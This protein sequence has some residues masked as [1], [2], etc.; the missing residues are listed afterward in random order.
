MG[1]FME[2]LS[3]PLMKD[4][5]TVKMIGVKTSEIEKSLNRLE[6]LLKTHNHNV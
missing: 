6:K 4:G 5:K 2:M 3:G 1:V